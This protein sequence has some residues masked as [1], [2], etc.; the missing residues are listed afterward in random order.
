MSK[1]QRLAEYMKNWQETEPR[2]LYQNFH[3]LDDTDKKKAYA[4][5]VRGTEF[6]LSKEGLEKLTAAPKENERLIG[7]SVVMGLSEFKPHTVNFVPI[8]GLTYCKEKCKQC[9]EHNDPYKCKD[10]IAYYYEFEDVKHNRKSYWGSDV[11]DG[12]SVVSLPFV[13]QVRNNWLDTASDQMADTVTSQ[14]PE[15]LERVLSYQIADAG[16]D[17]FIANREF[18]TDLYIYPGV[19]LNKHTTADIAFIPVFGLKFQRLADTDTSSLFRKHGFGISWKI[20]GED[21]DDEL[22]MDYS[23]P[24]PPTCV[25]PPPPPPGTGGDIYHE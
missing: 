6:R 13:D 8:L 19:D 3:K 11:D 17:F 4:F 10:N 7:I 12:S 9:R 18:L 24:C 25:P 16:L 14:S 22:F 21:E 1:D 5:F 20:N 2:E 15:G 23:R